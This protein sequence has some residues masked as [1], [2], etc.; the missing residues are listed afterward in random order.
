M[1]AQVW[2]MDAILAVVMV[3]MA[4]IGFFVFSSST[5]SQQ[6]TT[7]FLDESS[8][9]ANALGAQEANATL[10]IIADHMDE[11]RI[12]QLSKL[13]YTSLKRE[14]GIA[15]DFCVYFT[16]RNGNLIDIGGV[17]FLGSPYINLTVSGM[18]YSCNG[19]LWPS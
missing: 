7:S 1:K 14:L 8:L 15:S 18:H 3:V 13:D 6:R 12:M 5:L 11:K 2:S 16:D 19:T 9:L 4:V 17:R 10:S